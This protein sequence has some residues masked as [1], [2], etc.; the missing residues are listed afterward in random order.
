MS[1]EGRAPGS[2]WARA[3]GVPRPRARPD[4]LPNAG[5]P[6]MKPT[7]LLVNTSRAGLIE[8][9]ALLRA[10]EAGRPGMAALDVYEQEPL[11][12][13]SHPLLAMENVVCT[14]RIGYVTRDEYEIQFSD[15]FDQIIACAS[16]APIKRGQP[17]CPGVRGLEAARLK[18]ARTQV[19][20]DVGEARPRGRIAITCRR[21]ATAQG[22]RRDV[23]EKHD[24]A[25][26]FPI[27]DWRFRWRSW[28]CG[29]RRPA[30][31]GT[32]IRPAASVGRRIP[33]G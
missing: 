10:L 25:G 23:G 6:V 31:H 32:D 11:R 3:H 7:G 26:H 14:P 24:P 21:L 13:P 1:L 19:A 33:R 28:R 9:G 20:S 15:V 5:T 30:R 4:G 27:R 22:S 17:R 16:G 8:P 18:S 2:R 29:R 12:D